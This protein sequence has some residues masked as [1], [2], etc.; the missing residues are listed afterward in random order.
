[1][2]HAVPLSALFLE[3]VKNCNHKCPLSQYYHKYYGI[4]Q[5]I[6]TFIL[7]R[8]CSVVNDICKK[9]EERCCP[10]DA[11]ICVGG[12]KCCEGLKCKKSGLWEGRCIKGNKCL[13]ILRKLNII[14]IIRTVWNMKYYVFLVFVAGGI[15]CKPSGSRCRTDKECCSRQCYG[16]CM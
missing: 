1:M 5:A 8:I 16:H 10:R 14:I 15:K 9:E 4:D 6:D 2:I 12:G 13:L 3:V 7:F 11:M